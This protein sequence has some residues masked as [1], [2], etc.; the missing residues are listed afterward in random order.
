MTNASERS[1]STN[2]RDGEA[3]AW[4][5]RS[6]LHVARGDERWTLTDIEPRTHETIEV[7][8]LYLQSPR[9][10][11]PA[12]LLDAASDLLVAHLAGEGADDAR[13]SCDECGG[14]GQW[15]HCGPCS[16]RYGHAIEMRRAAVAKCSEWV[17][18]CCFVFGEPRDHIV[19]GLLHFLTRHQAGEDEKGTG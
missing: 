7:R 4:F 6:K 17:A 15:E 12:G 16:T 19:S 14:H 2:V 13:E 3:T 8:P 10:G 5:Y 9:T 18:G 1:S 11:I